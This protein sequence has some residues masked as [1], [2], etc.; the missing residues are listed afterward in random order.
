[1]FI[2]LIIIIITIIMIITIITIFW[3]QH[4]QNLFSPC[5]S[6]PDLCVLESPSALRAIILCILLFIT[7]IWNKLQ[8]NI[9]FPPQLQVFPVLGCC[10]SCCI[11]EKCL[12]QCLKGLSHGSIFLLFFIKHL[13]LGHCFSPLI[14]FAYNFKFAEIF[15][16]KVD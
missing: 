7:Q 12:S 11:K 4:Y 10:L 5:F 14:V 2:I 16:F 15:K 13:S 8:Q 6:N 1:M 9:S 3:I